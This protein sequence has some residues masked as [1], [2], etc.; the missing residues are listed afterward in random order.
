AVV[1]VT[2]KSGTNQ[3]HGSAWEYLRNSFFDATPYFQVAGQKPN[4]NQNQFGATLGGPVIKDR[5]F[6]FGS[7]QSLRSVNVAPQLVTVPTALQ[8][9][10]IFSTPISAPNTTAATPN[11]PGFVRSPFPN[12]TIPASMWDPVSTKLLALYP[13][14]N[15]K[16][17]TNFLSDQ[18]ER[19]SNDQY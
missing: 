6:V 2:L 5:T 19:L 4:F 7:W 3:L 14:P 12:N 16:R 1:N 18:A 15:I 11:G 13:L 10:G 9:R 17:A 8:R